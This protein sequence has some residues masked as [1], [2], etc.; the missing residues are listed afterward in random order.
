MN[1][2]QRVALLL[3]AVALALLAGCTQPNEPGGPAV[4]NQPAASQGGGGIPGY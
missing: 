4:S 1:V 3:A 2:R